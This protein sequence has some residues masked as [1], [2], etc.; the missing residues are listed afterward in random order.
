M[1]HIVTAIVGLVVCVLGLI[2]M[3]GN[4]SLLH[5]YHRKRVTEEN[6]KPFGRLAGLGLL[7]VGIAFVIFSVLLFIFEK[8]QIGILYKIANVE[9]IACIVVGL[10]ISFFAMIKYNKGIF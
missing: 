3:S 5:S 9:L 7:I 10:A 2:T 8:T 6:R 1:E 4:L